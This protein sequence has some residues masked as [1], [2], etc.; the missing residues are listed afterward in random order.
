MF[1][2]SEHHVEHIL[3]LIED[4]VPSLRGALSSAISKQKKTLFS[5][6]GATKGKSLIAFCWELFVMGMIAC[7]VISIINSLV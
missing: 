7:F 5:E 4:Y 1:S 6:S 3:D 2:F